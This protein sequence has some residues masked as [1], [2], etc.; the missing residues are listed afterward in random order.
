[1]RVMVLCCHPFHV[2]APVTDS[3]DS[4]WLVSSVDLVVAPQV[5]RESEHFNEFV[6]IVCI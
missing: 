4:E 6:M 3:G 2:R 1:V 5:V